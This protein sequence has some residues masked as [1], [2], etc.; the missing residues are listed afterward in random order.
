MT[1]SE[2][3]VVGTARFGSRQRKGVLL[4]LSGP[5]LTTLGAAA[6]L[7]TIGIFAAGWTG[8]L[9]AAPFDTALLACAYVRAGDTTLVEWAPVA[10]HWTARRATGQDRYLIR[11]AEPRPAGTLALPGDAAALRVHVDA[12]SGAAMIHDPHRRTLTVTCLVTHPAFVLLGAAD[13]ARRVTGWGR[14]LASLARTGHLAT[15][16]ICEAAVPDSGT[17]LLDYWTSHGRHDG[18][19][20]SCTYGEFLRVAAPASARHRTTISLTLDL[21]R[22]ARAIHRSGRGLT[23]A[24]AVLR[25]DM[26]AFGT[27]LRAAELTVARWL[28]EADLARITRGAYD[29][30]GA[31]RLDGTSLGTSLATAGPVGIR[32]HWAWFQS[33]SCV[34]AV[35]AI[36]EWPRSDTYPNFLHP[37]LLAPGIRKTVTLVA[38]PV[39]A[40]EARRDIRRQKVDYLTDAEQK[41]RLGQIADHTD[42]IEYADVLHREQELAAGHADLRYTGLIA[43]TAPDKAA[44]DEAVTA[45]EQ[46]AIHADCDT[47]LLVGQ[48]TQAF[49]AAALPLG[50]GL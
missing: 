24:A 26:T 5:R 20:Q 18:S 14:T 7:L 31:A 39:P 32:E 38:H 44:L 15:V 34:T 29:P 35:L 42:T 48:Q 40:Y 46:A 22:A 19:W 30:D 17:D 49:T 37:L 25:S 50:R 33:D 11:L 9:F 13:Q 8:L 4:G 41:A 10:L 12:V 2:T 47:R 36:T 45:V 6:L 16:Q 43:V 21:R 3:T 27:A 28:S 1:G 23:G